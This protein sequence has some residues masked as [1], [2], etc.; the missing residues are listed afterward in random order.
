M[1][2]MRQKTFYSESKRQKILAFAKETS[3]QEAA[4]KFQMPVGTLYHWI[5]FPNGKKGTYKP[6]AKEGFVKL[7]TEHNDEMIKVERNGIIFSVPLNQLKNVLDILGGTY[8]G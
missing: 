7:P 8:E 1:E 2:T 3:M 4:N 6:K 5:R